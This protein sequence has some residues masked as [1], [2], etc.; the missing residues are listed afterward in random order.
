MAPPFRGR[1]AQDARTSDYE[2]ELPP[3]L[4][5]THPAPRREES[6][7]LVFDRATDRVEHGEF[8]DLPNFLRP[9]DLLVLNDS[10]VR[11]A[12]LKTTDGR[13]EVLLLEETSPQHWVAL[14]KPGAR[15]K[16]GMRLFFSFA[17]GKG[18]R[19]GSPEDAVRWGA[20]A[21]LLLAVRTRGAG[22]NAAAPLHPEAAYRFG[23][24]RARG[25]RFRSLPDR[26]CPGGRF[27]R[28]S[29]GGAAFYAGN[30]RPIQARLRHP[31][32]RLGY[33]SARSK[34][35]FSM[36]MT[37]T[38][39]LT[40]FRQDWR[41]RVPGPG[42]SSRSEP[43]RRVCSSPPRIFVRAGAAP[44]FSSGRRT[45]FSGSTPC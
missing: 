27:G 36:T 19:S 23:R 24:S 30:A 18:N 26:L 3:E 4:I 2:Y 1:P 15:A 33:F 12:A 43:H 14:V 44:G 17:H 8:R 7:L 35:N 21:A 20:G 32:R 45:S 29:D 34:R 11:P 42:A 39:R 41:K 13:L 5:A 25:R 16:P 28:R 10:K 37:C 22:R 31:S 6:R 9:D 38:R 40:R